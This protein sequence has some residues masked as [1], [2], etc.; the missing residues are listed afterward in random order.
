MSVLSQTELEA[1][2]RRVDE[3]PTHNFAE[4]IRIAGLDP[5]KH[6]R[7]ADWTGVDFRGCNLR[8]FDFTGSRLIGCNFEHARI[9]GARFDQALID[10]VRPGAKLD[11]DRTNLRAAKDWDKHIKSWT[12]IEKPVPENLPPG[13]VFQDAPFAPEMVVIPPGRFWMGSKYSEGDADERPR[14]E[15]TIPHALAVGR[16]PVTPEEWYAAGAAGTVELKSRSNWS[17]RLLGRDSVTSVSWHDAQAYVSWL[18]GKTGKPYRLLSEAEWEYAC[19]AG[20]ETAYS[21][22]DSISKAQAQ[23]SDGSFAFARSTVG[24]GSFSANHFGL[25]DMHGNVWEWCEDSFHD[26][27][28]AKPEGL[29]ETGGAWTNGESSFH[30]LRGGSSLSLPPKLRSAY[31]SGNKSENPGGGDVG[32]RVA[33]TLLPS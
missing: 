18:S 20:T 13:A 25:Y 14:H 1:R 9:E 29:K 28:A 12:R 19:R 7:F 31:R 33:R 23:F 11:P 3:A 15:V 2:E 17:A 24:A 22:G 8:G 26:S 27:Y 32:F 6:L 4:L 5:K 10:E 16:L 30:V 21:F